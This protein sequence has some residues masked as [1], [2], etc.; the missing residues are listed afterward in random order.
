MIGLLLEGRDNILMPEG[1]GHVYCNCVLSS[2]LVTWKV[3]LT[4]VMNLDIVFKMIHYAGHSIML[5][6]NL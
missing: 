6:D 5:W 4:K 1:S 3:S 2:L